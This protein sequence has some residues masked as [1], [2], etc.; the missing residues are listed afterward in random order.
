MEIVGI[1]VGYSFTKTST[2]MI[3]PSKITTAEP[4]MGYGRT[5]KWNNTL[6]YVG[7]GIGT[8][9]MNKTNEDVTAVLTL[10]ALCGSLE[11]QSANVVVG[12]PIDL[13]K[14]QRESL[15][16]S[17]MK[18]SGTVEYNGEQKQITIEDCEVYPQ[19]LLPVE[20]DYVSVDIGG[21]T[22]DI[23]YIEQS[24]VKYKRTMYQGM[25]SLYGKIVRKINEMY[26]SKHED[27][28]AERVLID[29]LYVKGKKVDI[30]FLNPIFSEHVESIV[31]EV[32]KSTPAKMASIYITGGGASILHEAIKAKLPDAMLWENGQ[33]SNAEVYQSVGEE[34]WA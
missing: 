2:G 29:G 13:Y 9:S 7:T 19:G 6:Y 1:D 12:L 8:V 30:S 20:G 22:V 4:M 17:V 21:C 24:E 28:Y 33:F 25:Q 11:G 31:Q 16:A 34:I 23:V 27:D 15:R 18:L 26:E 5:L 10:Y 3:F 14:A 32:K